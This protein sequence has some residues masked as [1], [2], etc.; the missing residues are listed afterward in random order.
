MELVLNMPIH[1]LSGSDS[2]V[3]SSALACHKEWRERVL[4]SLARASHKALHVLV[5]IAQEFET[6]QIAAA[7]QCKEAA[8]QLVQKD[9]S[10]SKGKSGQAAGQSIGL[11]TV[12]HS[13]SE[14]SPVAKVKCR[15]HR[16]PCTCGA[17]S[18]DASAASVCKDAEPVSHTKRARSPADEASSTNGTCHSSNPEAVLDSAEDLHL[19]RDN[20]LSQLCKGA[21]QSLMKH[22]RCEFFLVPGCL[23]LLCV[24][25][26]FPCQNFVS[27]VI[28][29]CTFANAKAA[30]LLLCAQW[31]HLW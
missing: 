3:R 28:N 19:A 18:N 4:P 14:G 20:T 2:K 11:A 6:E 13:K 9:L 25:N 16:K 15:C 12:S 29:P 21:L 24:S 26:A 27:V 7:A 30:L 22:R 23:H 1:L 5:E 31:R 10:K 8:S 17:R